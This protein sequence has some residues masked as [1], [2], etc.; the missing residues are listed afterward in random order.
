[1]MGTFAMKPTGVKSLSTSNVSFLNRLM[2]IAI[3][4]PFVSSV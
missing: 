2:L 1:M 3:V 4:T